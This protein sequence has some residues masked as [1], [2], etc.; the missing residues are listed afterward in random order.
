MKRTLAMCAAVL[1][2][3]FVALGPVPSLVWA[4]DQPPE[5]PEPPCEN[6]PPGTG[7][8]QDCIMDGGWDWHCH[9]VSWWWYQGNTDCRNERCYDPLIGT[10]AC[11]NYYGQTCQYQG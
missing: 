2:V 11:C 8:C 9:D 10:Y 4:E 6:C 1:G 3:V 5:Y 7:K